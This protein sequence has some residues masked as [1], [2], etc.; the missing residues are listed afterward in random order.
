MF[1][2]LDTE[3]KELKDRT[4]VNPI[5]MV[6]YDS[7]TST[8]DSFDLR[9]SDFK[10]VRAYI[11]SKANHIFM[12]FNIAAEIG[13]L[14]KFLTLNE[15][16]V[17]KFVDLWVESKQ[18]TLTF[19]PYFTKDT[20]LLGVLKVFGLV[21]LYEADKEDVLSIILQNETYTDEQFED[22]LKYCKEDVSI[23]I[24]LQK[25]IFE[26]YDDFNE[27]QNQH[28]PKKVFKKRDILKRGEFCK[29]KAINYSITEGFPVNR[30]FLQLIFE[31][32]EAIKLQFMRDLNEKTGFILFRAKVK[33]RPDELSFNTEEFEKYLGEKGLLDAWERTKCGR[34]R[35]DEDYTDKMLSNN[36]DVLL[37]FVQTRNT[38]K[39]LN[40]TN[41]YEICSPDGFIKAPPFPFHQK[42]SRSS[43]KPAL[44]FLPN[45][46][47]WLRMLITPPKGKVFAIIDFKAQEVLAAALMS[48]DKE[49]LDGYLGDLYLK[50][51]ILTGFAPAE[52]TKETHKNIR[53]FFK[54]ACIAE[55]ELVLTNNGFKP[56]EQLKIED[57]IWT[58]EEFSKHGGVIN[59]KEVELEELLEIK[60]TFITKDHLIYTLTGWE[61]GENIK[62][63]K[64]IYTPDLPNIG[65]TTIWKLVCL[66]FTTFFKKQ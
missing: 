51:A 28:E 61:R 65:W 34:I 55:G 10:E 18:L 6:C 7:N 62:D 13:V 48:Q 49:V 27:S 63:A 54:M 58:G 8:Y 39:Q 2:L 64:S 43:P 14:I 9:N 26:F 33:K 56:I 4:N 20:S 45:L 47:P 21:S 40:S 24:H 19:K 42:S 35:L 38:L 17:M 44:G 41:L 30:Q 36:K 32:R 66:I 12:S 29:I 5:C 37:D 60:D 1:L 59:T 46:T 50:T 11:L 31:H 22:I 15:L 25:F 52:A 23:L 16:A 53:N 3:Y 57:F